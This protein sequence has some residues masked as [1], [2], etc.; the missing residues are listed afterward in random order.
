MIDDETGSPCTTGSEGEQLS[1][2]MRHGSSAH[3]VNMSHSPHFTVPSLLT[4]IFHQVK[5]PLAPAHCQLNNVARL[6]A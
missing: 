3:W 6:L 1:R 4:S 5:H 2:L